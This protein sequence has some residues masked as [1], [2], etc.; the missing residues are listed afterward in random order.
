MLWLPLLFILTSFSRH[1]LWLPPRTKIFQLCNTF[2][3]ACV[4]PSLLTVSSFFSPLPL[5]PSPSSPLSLFSPLP[6]LPSL[7]LPQPF[8]DGVLH[9][10]TNKPTVERSVQTH[11]DIETNRMGRERE[12]VK[13]DGRERGSKGTG[14]REGERRKD[15]H[16]ER[17]T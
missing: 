13:R 10:N 15:T 12:R 4:F 9:A 3:F 16:L 7:F 5:L 17:H 11:T 8:K 2:S 14:E 6:L 1:P